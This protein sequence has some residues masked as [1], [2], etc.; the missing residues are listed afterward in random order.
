MGFLSLQLPLPGE[1]SSKNRE[2]GP[3]RVCMC[4]CCV[5]L[6]VCGDGG[7]GVCVMCSV[8]HMHERRCSHLCR[9]VCTPDIHIV[10]LPLEISPLFFK[11]VHHQIQS[12]PFHSD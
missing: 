4:V 3:S 1:I 11:M 8:V 6:S 9:C 5:G 10:H 2:S 7:M 12:L